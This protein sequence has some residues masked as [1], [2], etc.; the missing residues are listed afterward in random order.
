MRDDVME[1]IQVNFSFNIQKCVSFALKLCL[2]YICTCCVVLQSYIATQI[3]VDS[4]MLRGHRQ[5][6]EQLL[7]LL[8]F[9]H[10][11]NNRDLFQP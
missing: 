1:Q 2:T 7:L 9:L 8:L 10:A 3:M 5:D 6:G 4:K 11:V